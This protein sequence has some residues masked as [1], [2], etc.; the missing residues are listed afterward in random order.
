MYMQM[1]CM[2]A[3]THIC[4]YR[5]LDNDGEFGETMLETER[6]N[7]NMLNSRDEKVHP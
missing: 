2:R 1:L 5:R 3:C 4:V 6:T 7:T